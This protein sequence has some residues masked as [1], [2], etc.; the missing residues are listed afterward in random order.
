MSG[1]VGSQS[2]T[3]SSG[4][5]GS[6]GTIKPTA[7]LGGAIVVVDPASLTPIALIDTCAT[8]SE[9]STDAKSSPAWFPRRSDSA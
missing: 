9:D 7:I 5:I 6:D 8:A 2:P 3:S 1:A 4:G